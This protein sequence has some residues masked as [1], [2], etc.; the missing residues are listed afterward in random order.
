MFGRRSIGWLLVALGCGALGEAAEAQT[1]LLRFPDIHGERLVFTYGGDLWTA[2]TSGGAATRLTAHPGLEVFAKFSPDGRWIAFTGQYDGDEQVYVVESTGGVPRQLTFY[3]AAGPLPPR[4]GYDNQVYG[5]TP[6]GDSV[7]FRSLRDGW[8][9]GDSQL[10]TVSAQGG[11]PTALPMPESGAGDFSPD[12]QRVVYSPL[13]RDFRHWKRYEGGWAQELYLFDLETYDTVRVSDHPRADRDPMWIG[14][15]IYF[16]SDRDDKNN[17]YAYDVASGTTRQV[18]T[19]TVW[20]IRWPSADRANRRIVYELNGELQVLDLASGA[21]RRVAIHVPD[22]GIARRPARVSVANQVRG[23]GL[24]PTG[25]RAVFAARGDLFTVP[26]EHGPSRNLTRTSG[27]HD[28]EPAWSP[29]GQRIAFVSD[30][31]GEEE[32]WLVDQDGKSAPEQLTD[33][34]RGRLHGLAW[35]PDGELIACRD[36]GQRLYIVEV[37]SGEKR[38]IA[39]D[40]ATFGLTYGWSPRSG[41]L[42]FT[43][44]QPSGF[45]SL[46]LWSRAEDRVRQITDE[47]FH[48]FSPTFGPKGD[49]LFYLSPREWRPQLG[50]F[51][52]NYVL[53]REVQLYALALRRDVAHPF[54]PRSDEVVIEEASDGEDLGAETKGKSKKDSG[55]DEADPDEADQDE[56]P[57]AIDFEGLAQRKARVPAPADNYLGL[58]AGAGHLLA[59]RSGAGYYGRQS[60]TAPGLRLLTFDDRQMST[61]VEG[62]QGATLSA[63]GKKLLV[64]QNGG[65]K[66]LDVKPQGGDSAKPVSTAGLAV[67]LV[68]Q[69]QWR[70]I[71]HEA[72]RR[73]RDFFYLE[74]MGGVD[75]LAIRQ[76]YEPWLEHVAHR[77]DLND[78]IAEMIGELGT[79]HTYVQGG[80]FDTPE[81][82][83][84]GLL[85]ARFELDEAAGRYRL[86]KI[87]RGDNAEDNYR[88]PL[89][90]IGVDAEVGDYVL[91]IAGQELGAGDNP[92]RLLR[93]AGN[94]PLELTLNDRPMLDDGARSLLVQP[95]ASED[96]LIYLDWTRRS[97]RRVHEASDGKVGY[98]HLP[99]MGASGLREWIKGFYSQ[100]RKDGL[101]IDVRSNG[102]GNVSQM[103]IDRLRRELLMVDF[104]RHQENPDPYPGTVFTGHLVCLLDEDTASDG[105]QFAWVFRQAG[106]G[107]LVGKRSWGGVVGIYGRGPLIDGGSVSVSEAGTTDPDGRWVIE[108]HGVEPDYEVENPPSALLAGR[109]PQLEKGLEL[110]LQKIATEPRG[111]PAAPR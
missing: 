57:I 36:E 19:E 40:P 95:I 53:N 47:E 65:F 31:D 74:D 86:A 91:R 15:E 103:I 109:D 34:H 28:R 25:K 46:Y 110:L 63:D 78:V 35:S 38:Q 96:D 80:D 90:E 54:P 69:E 55:A 64:G 104:E 66:L 70:Q 108:G 37:A 14:G 68:P 111:L 5:W 21:T 2:S 26:I 4:W 62:M 16:T 9:V 87:F 32:I 92:F 85:G 79:S 89:T 100:I 97:R 18:T 22:D 43:L 58:S 75:W 10:F 83:R 17:L 102:G 44:A 8:D 50:S 45:R 59:L 82:P 51:E 24:S 76:Q 105:D 72:W 61:L 98:I 49:Y 30:Q 42:A 56:T 6:D 27:A 12:G 99:N 29:D 11:L 93:H 67:D 107:P 1:K 39:D 33:G 101:I 41:H 48:E 13:V 7:L 71:F 3:P 52:F 20:D 81:R 88:S 77:T 23:M 84:A 73:F 106:L 60:E 94:G